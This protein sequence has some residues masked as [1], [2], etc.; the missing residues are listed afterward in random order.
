M[1]VVGFGVIEPCKQA[2]NPTLTAVTPKPYFQ[3]NYRVEECTVQRLAGFDPS[4][5][6]RGLAIGLG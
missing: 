2:S 3:G 4:I 6:L 1:R 5:G